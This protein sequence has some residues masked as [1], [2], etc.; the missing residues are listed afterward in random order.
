MA[1]FCAVLRDAVGEEKSLAR[2]VAA[3][4]GKFVELDSSASEPWV[5]LPWLRGFEGARL[6]A[7]E[8]VEQSRR[9]IYPTG[10]GPVWYA[11][12]H[13]VGY[14]ARD[15]GGWEMGF[16]GT[17]GVVP[18][19]DCGWVPGVPNL[20]QFPV[21]G[22]KAERVA[23]GC[24]PTAAGN[25]LGYWLERMGKES[26]KNLGQ[27]ERAVRLKEFTRQI[28]GRLRMTEFL[29]EAGYTEEGMPLAG[30]FPGELVEPI[31]EL[32][33][34]Q[35]LELRAVAGA[36][37]MEKYRGE[38]GGGRPVLLSCVVRLP[39]KPHL[40]WGHEVV[41]IGWGRGRGREWVLVRDNFFPPGEDT[42]VRVLP[43]EVF[44]EMV[45]V[46]P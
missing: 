7:G 42:Q 44:S 45:T 9:Q 41:G 38:I 46:S 3:G 5:G 40:S 11:R 30:A 23:S 36:F 39:H 34:S 17:A 1:G 27:V 28:R 14:F 13:P 16:W 4:S 26:W 10:L 35:G 33:R 32:G 19:A 24:V 18:G 15:D 8:V 20:Q 25:V 43:K 6:G 22:K 31:M 12:I 21:P 2:F 37:D 29:D